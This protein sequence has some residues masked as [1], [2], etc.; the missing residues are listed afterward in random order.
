MKFL[1]LI[2]DGMADFPLPERGGRTPL[3]LASTPAMDTLASEGLCG[4]YWPI[5]DDL[6]P[7]S[8]IGNLSLFGYNPHETFTGRA[9]LEAANQHRAGVPGC[10]FRCNLVA[11]DG[12]MKSF[13]SDHLER[14]S[15]G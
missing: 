15:G 14:G 8:D 13:T 7:G 12:V 3:Q 10:G 9:P 4:L 5:P 1:C 11:S 2:G 6:P